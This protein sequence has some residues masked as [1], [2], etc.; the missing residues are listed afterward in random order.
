MTRFEILMEGVE[1][2]KVESSLCDEFYKKTG[3]IV[4]ILPVGSKEPRL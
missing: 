2:N 4:K 1:E 3:I